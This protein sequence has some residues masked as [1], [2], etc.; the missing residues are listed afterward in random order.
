VLLII[1]CGVRNEWTEADRLFKEKDYAAA[2][3][4][5]AKAA[6]KF[7]ERRELQ[8]NVACARHANEEFDDAI[9]RFQTLAKE[10]SGELQQKSEYNT[11]NGYLRSQDREK[12]IEHYKRALYLDHTDMD[13]K[14]NLELAMSR[15]QQQD[16]QQNQDNKQ[17]KDQDEKQQ[18]EKD[19]K[20]NQQ[21]QQQQDQQQQERDEKQQDENDQQ[22]QNQAD[23]KQQDEKDQQQQDQ[24]RQPQVGEMSQKDAERLLSG[25]SEEDKKLQK[26][27]RKPEDTVRQPPRGK[28]W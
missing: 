18:Q 28:D 5:Y 7:P 21:D 15:Q 6:E 10:T 19:E 14:W 24:Q 12:A 22:Q 8:F 11:G 25:L 23:E 2:A 1:G 9:K 4:A 17:D 20:D 27:L 26:A 13:A 16:Q 3:E